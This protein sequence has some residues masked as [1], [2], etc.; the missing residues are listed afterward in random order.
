MSLMKPVCVTSL[1]V[2]S[3]HIQHIHNQVPQCFNNQHKR[4][5]QIHKIIELPNYLND[6]NCFGSNHFLAHVHISYLFLFQTCFWLLLS[7]VHMFLSHEYFGKGSASFMSSNLRAE[8]VCD[9]LY[10]DVSQCLKDGVFMSE[11][12]GKK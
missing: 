2:L 1:T 5:K 7:R 6:L 8:Y 4:R 12:V 9:C 3:L 11:C 10:C